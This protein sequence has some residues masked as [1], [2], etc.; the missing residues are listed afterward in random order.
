MRTNQGLAGQVRL[1]PDRLD[2]DDLVQTSRLERGVWA[3][4]NK[5]RSEQELTIK[6]QPTIITLG[7]TFT[8]AQKDLMEDADVRFVELP[9]VLL[10]APSPDLIRAIAEDYF[11]PALPAVESQT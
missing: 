10:K 7:G 1:S 11:G 5:L 3:L 8:Q 2:A 6:L 4:E 9:E